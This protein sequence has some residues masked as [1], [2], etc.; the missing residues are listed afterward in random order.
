MGQDKGKTK[1]D[2]D[3]FIWKTREGC[4]A[5]PS[6]GES[7]PTL[8]EVVPIDLQHAEEPSTFS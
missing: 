6:I 8:P 2:P 1:V 3:R 7:Q 5:E 4:Y